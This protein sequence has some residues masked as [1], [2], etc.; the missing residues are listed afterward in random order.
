[1]K[2]EVAV[3]KSGRG[4]L[5]VTLFLQQIRA[6]KTLLMCNVTVSDLDLI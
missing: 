1:M 6:T 3:S 2:T 5:L 4:I